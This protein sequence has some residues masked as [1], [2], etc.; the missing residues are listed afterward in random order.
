MRCEGAYSVNCWLRPNHRAVVLFP[1]SWPGLSWLVPAIHA[2]MPQNWE[3]LLASN[4]DNALA[5][6]GRSPAAWMAGTSPA[7]TFRFAS[8]NS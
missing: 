1:P 3:T 5:A 4:F 7:M 2:E 6:L 8:T